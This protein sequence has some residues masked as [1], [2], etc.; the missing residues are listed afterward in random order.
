MTWEE[1]KEKAKEIGYDIMDGKVKKNNIGFYMSGHIVVFTSLSN[2]LVQ[3][4]IAT[5]RTTDQMW[6]IVEALQ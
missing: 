2:C 6:K 3:K 4:V 1:F 5:H